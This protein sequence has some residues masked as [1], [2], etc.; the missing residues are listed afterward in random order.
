[1]NHSGDEYVSK[2]RIER[3]EVH[4]FRFEMKDMA[5]DATGFNLVYKKGSV[6]PGVSYAMK[7]HTNDG[8]S[9]EY[10]GG[11]SPT[12]AEF[13]MIARTLIGADPMQREKI[14][15]EGKRA[16][17][18]YDKMGLGPI[19]IALWDLAGKYYGA[20]VSELLGGWKSVL[21]CYASTYHGDRN[22]GLDSPEAYA[23]FA[24]ECKKLGYPAFKIHGWSDST[25][26]DEAETIRKVRTKVGD[27]MDLMVDPASEPK[28]FLAALKIG[29]ACDEAG[30]LWLEDPYMDTGIS[31]HGHRQ[32][33]Q[34][35]RT[36]ILA[37]EH[38]RGLE[39]HVDFIATDSTDIVRV[40]PEYDGG[41]TGAMKIAHAAEGFGL[42]V[43]IHAPGPAHR[44]LMSAL[45]NTNYYEMAL[46]HPCT[47]EFGRPPVYTC[48]YQDGLKAIDE[49]GC[50]PVPAG[51]GLG[52]SYD[53]DFIM[54]NR[55]GG[56][57]YE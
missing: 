19:D 34:L 18:K 7:V 25:M 29:R 9:G 3:I 2:L 39:Q 8:V 56:R 31:Q 17:R 53:W 40:D 16:L 12:F 14:Y 13:N 47:D 33:R 52:V 41:I 30:Y 35:I 54:A 15:N 43:E 10:V 42:D 48:G 26:R 36:P 1:M 38:V 45:R 22:G 49:R 23:D 46:V 55:L 32:L 6:H 24:L 20:S 27:D 44:H 11:C 57:T 4:E 21:P 37:T 51:A 28:T 5:K 50:V